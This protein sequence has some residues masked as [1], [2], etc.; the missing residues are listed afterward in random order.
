MSAPG[1]RGIH[2]S[3]D[4]ELGSIQER[5]VSV[6]DRNRTQ[7]ERGRIRCVGTRRNLIPRFDKAQKIAQALSIPFGYLFLS[8]PPE[9]ATPLP[10]MRTLA[11][12]QPLSL[13]FLEVVNDA[14]VKQDWYRDYLAGNK[15]EQVPV[16]RQTRIEGCTD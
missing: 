4:S 14:L 13:N 9:L 10:D 12:Q 16:R 7:G 3:S 8:K 5:K 1:Q 15:R 6:R 11:D 2:K